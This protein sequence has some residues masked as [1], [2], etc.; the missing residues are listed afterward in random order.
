M[1][2]IS[3]I[4]CCAVAAVAFAA[5]MP[6]CMP[7][8]NVKEDNSEKPVPP[9]E[10]TPYVRLYK[11]SFDT[12]DGIYLGTDGRLS[13]TGEWRF[14]SLGPL[15]SITKIDYIPY[16]PWDEDANIGMFYSIVAY[17]PQKGFMRLYVGSMTMNSDGELSSVVLYY[18]RDF[19]G[20]DVAIELDRT[21]V[22]VEAGA[23]TV[24]IDVKNKNYTPFSAAPS[25]RWLKSKTL[26]TNGGILA[27]AVEITIEANTESEPRT[28]TVRVATQNNKST[29]ITVKQD[30]Y[31]A[32]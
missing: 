6:A 18:N 14:S 27:N 16:G 20:E 3:K 4:I 30:G 5:A 12:F 24:T 7:D 22:S 2:R 31:T 23:S 28:S 19:R 8:N 32:Q 29:I 26:S 21:E 1:T 15:P 11:G 25:A 9:P 17:H 13:S 10:G